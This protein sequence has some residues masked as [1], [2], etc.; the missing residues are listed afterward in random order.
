M[1]YL[2]WSIK[3]TLVFLTYFKLEILASLIHSAV[4]I[5][6]LDEEAV[7]VTGQVRKK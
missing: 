7:L 1:S 6:L 4:G 2:S 3:L 5:N